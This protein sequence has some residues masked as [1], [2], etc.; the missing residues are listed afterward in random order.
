MK[1]GAVC[2]MGLVVF[3]DIALWF[4][5]DLSIGL[6]TVGVVLSCLAIPFAGFI[7]WEGAAEKR[8][9]PETPEP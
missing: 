6:R 7:C 1:A 9:I 2:A 3:A 4:W 5:P 8:R